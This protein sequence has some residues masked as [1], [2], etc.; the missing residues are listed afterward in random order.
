MRTV[1]VAAL[2]SLL[3]ASA[4]KQDQTTSAGEVIPAGA[5]TPTPETPRRDAEK[6]SR[7][8]RAALTRSVA[9]LD[10]TFARL[11]KLEG[12]L[13]L[14]NALDAWDARQHARAGKQLQQA[15]DNLE[16]G[17][18]RVHLELDSADLAAAANARATA[19]RLQQSGELGADEFWQ[20]TD[21]LDAALRS[22]GARI[23][24]KT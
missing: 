17:A 13:H 21:K 1:A 3:A 15:A 6:T 2:A 11:E 22:L 24:R 20:V 7:A 4:C 19:I 16:R 8:A 12:L 10:S 9:E 14:V 5:P 23:G 18:R